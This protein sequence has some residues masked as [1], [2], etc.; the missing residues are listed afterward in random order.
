MLTQN[1]MVHLPKYRWVRNVIFRANSQQHVRA[2]PKNLYRS[3]R[4]V[5]TTVDMTSSRFFG[6]WGN[7]YI[8]TF[9]FTKN[10]MFCQRTLSFFGQALNNTSERSEVSF[11]GLG[12][13]TTTPR[14]RCCCLPFYQIS[15]SKPS[16]AKCTFFGRHFSTFAWSPMWCIICVKY[17]SR[18]E[19]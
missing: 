17:V 10:R 8:I 16:Y 2:Q 19:R 18:G 15:T 11:L 4:D 1:V 7:S 6:I 9:I 12:G 3:K 5:S 13:W 14:Q